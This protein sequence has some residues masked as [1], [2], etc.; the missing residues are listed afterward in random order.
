MSDTRLLITEVSSISNVGVGLQATADGLA[1]KQRT[2]PVKAFDFHEL[3]REVACY[4]IDDFDPVAILGKKG[5][6]SKDFATK[7]VLATIELGQKGCFGAEDEGERPGLSIGTALGS[8][9]SI[10]DFL[11]DSIVNGVNAVNPMHFANTVINSPTGNA[12]IR[13]GTKS[14][15][16]TISTG[17]NAGIDA[18]IY[19]CDHIRCGYLPAIVAGGVEE[20]SYY[21]LLGMERSGMLSHGDASRPFAS[22]ADGIVMG[23]GCALFMVETQDSAKGRGASPVAEIV[24]Y[25]CLFDPS[26]GRLGFNPAGEGA[27]RAIEQACNMA[28]IQPGDVG[29]VAADGNGQR[30]GDTMEARVIA[31][32]L[33]DTPVAAYK[34]RT[35][36]C[37]GASPAL[38]LAC[39]LSDIRNKRISGT[40]A[41]YEVDSG[42]AL[43]SEDITGRETEY[44]LLTAFSCDGNCSAMVIRNLN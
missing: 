33:G 39:A 8:L 43:V 1:G 10:G 23:E 14:L 37:Y 13:Y 34:A 42:I 32:L 30:A 38:S 5:L 17:F 4:R 12:N 35:G 22:D 36:E 9:Q 19:A 2:S 28:G 25:S 41:S 16:A 26:E 7:L 6:R 29:F 40:G 11:S 31:E 44:L 27:R 15:S 20:I 18:I 21:T 3:D 24:G